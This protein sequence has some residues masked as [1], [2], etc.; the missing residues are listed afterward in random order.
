M[1]PNVI[2]VVWRWDATTGSSSAV[3]GVARLQ[4]SCAA[5]L[6]PVSEWA[7]SPSPGSK[8]CFLELPPIRL[9]ALPSFCHTTGNPFLPDNRTGNCK[10]L[11]SPRIA[12][13][14]ETLYLLMVPVTPH[15]DHGTVSSP[16]N[17]PV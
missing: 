7:W 14:W 16:A 8:T 17:L 2:S 11:N 9:T 5:S 3:T 13:H 4:P 15:P 10:T 6:H 1:P 12:A